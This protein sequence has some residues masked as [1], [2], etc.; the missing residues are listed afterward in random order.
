[1]IRLTVPS[2]DEADF[3]AVR[4]VL[5]SGFLVQGSKVAAFEQAVADCVETQHAVAVSSGT[6]ALHL[7]L[8]A[9]G[10]GPADIVVTTAYSHPATANVVELCGAR[11]I[12]VDIER[13]T[14]NMDPDCLESTLKRLM[15]EA[16]TARRVKVL[17][18]VH[19]FGQLAKMPAILAIASKYQLPVVEDA[20]CALGAKLH[21]R[22]AGSW[23]VMACFSFH[24]RKAITTG[25]GGIIATNDASLARRLRALRNHG[26]DADAPAGAFIMP[27]YN[28]RMTELQGALGLAQ[29]VKLERIVAVR[30]R[31]AAVYD[32]L[33]ANTPIAPPVVAADSEP[34]YQS[35]VPLLAGDLAQRRDEL[36]RESRAQGI[37]T[38]IGTW[39]I[40]LTPYYRTKYAF[41]R[42]LLP[43]ADAV[44]DR[45]ISLPLHEQ[46]STAD[47]QAVVSTLTDQLARPAP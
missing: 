27:G 9:L 3:K 34:T 43:G 29:M 22:Q 28:Y 39:H 1:M 6:S 30:R 23:G 26:Q 46:L 4:E 11:P 5:E 7:A 17:L 16:S 31:L 14:Y 18:P 42:G 10:V 32:R 25:E 40:P 33:L 21:G 20:A 2:I 44:F 38:T 35:Y 41:H 47:Q 15:A 36:I 24:P 19:A 45:T 8:L 12:F 37:E 13:D